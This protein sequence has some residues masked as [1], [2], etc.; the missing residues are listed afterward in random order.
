V[1]FVDTGFIFAYVSEDD[2][3]HARVVEVLEDYRGRRL[4]D[5]L[6]TINHVIAETITL[7]RSK[8]HRDAGLRHDL[9]V[10][11]GQQ[12][13]GSVFGRIHQATAEEER[14]AFAYLARHRDKDYSFVDRLSFV[15]MDKLGIG[16]A[17]AVDS[18]F[19]HHFT[20]RPGPRAR[21]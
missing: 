18:D 12:L 7:V 15:V 6:L 2:V 9:A 13:F 1:I 19:T 5:I 20:A 11:V 21:P 3:D 4:G 8:G 10:K 17:L 14:E 16:E